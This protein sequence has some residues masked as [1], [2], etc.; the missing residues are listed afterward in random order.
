MPTPIESGSGG[1]TGQSGNDSYRNSTGP[2]KPEGCSLSVGV[3]SLIVGVLS[4]VVV[5]MHKEAR[6]YFG[7]DPALTPTPAAAKTV[8][9]PSRVALPSLGTAGR[10]ALP[11]PVG[12]PTGIHIDELSVSARAIAPFRV[13]PTA[14]APAGRMPIILREA[15]YRGSVR[16]APF[17]L[18]LNGDDNTVVVDLL[19][20]TDHPHF[21]S[22][23]WEVTGQTRPLPLPMNIRIVLEITGRNNIVK[24]PHRTENAGVKSWHSSNRLYETSP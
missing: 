23:T 16:A 24:I 15:L 12:P 9:S 2:P 18:T 11:T 22:Q 3:A 19:S 8:S 10:L 4:V 17:V 13:E 20:P 5:I 7:L 14:A 21:A 6:L 1:F